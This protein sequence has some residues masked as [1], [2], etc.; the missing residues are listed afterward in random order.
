MGVCGCGVVFSPAAMVVIALNNPPPFNSSTG[1]GF[2]RLTTNIFG[3]R[4]RT[5]VI[6]VCLLKQTGLLICL[7]LLLRA[8]ECVGWV[9]TCYIEMTPL[10]SS[11]GV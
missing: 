8:A 11:L 6:G 9:H 7:H 10:G 5:H 1:P 3:C 4:G 2:V